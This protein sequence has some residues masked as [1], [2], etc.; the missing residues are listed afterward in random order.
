MPQTYTIEV[1]EELAVLVGPD[2]KP[3]ARRAFL[4]AFTPHPA[5]W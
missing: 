3:F 2:A 5:E 1:D 4:D